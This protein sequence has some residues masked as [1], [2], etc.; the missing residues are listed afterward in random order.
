MSW[1]GKHQTLGVVFRDDE[2]KALEPI[3]ITVKGS[4]KASMRIYEN[5]DH[6]TTIAAERTISAGGCSGEIGSWMTTPSHST[7][8]VTFAKTVAP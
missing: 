1:R 2:R 4:L 6:P 7:H 8:R 3:G 5:D